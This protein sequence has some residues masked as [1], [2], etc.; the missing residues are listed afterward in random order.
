MQDNCTCYALHMITPCSNYV[1]RASILAIVTDCPL[2]EGSWCE[3]KNAHKKPNPQNCTSAGIF[4]LQGNYHIYKLVWF[5]IDESTQ[6]FGFLL[7]WERYRLVYCFKVGFVRSLW[8]NFASRSQVFGGMK[9]QNDAIAGLERKSEYHKA[10][11]VNLS[12]KEQN[13]SQWILSFFP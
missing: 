7:L 3:A 6:H 11:I 8:S 10:S 1:F 12:A 4:L 9:P 5:L 2:S 13:Y